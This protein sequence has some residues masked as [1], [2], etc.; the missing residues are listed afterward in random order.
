MI[1]TI[2]CTALSA[3][4]PYQKNVIGTK[5]AKNMHAGSRISGSKTPS[6]AFVIRTTVASEIFERNELADSQ[7]GG[8]DK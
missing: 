8:T 4:Q 5:K 1:G 2:Q 7:S 6:F 3:D